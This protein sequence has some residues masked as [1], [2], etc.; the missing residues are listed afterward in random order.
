MVRKSTVWFP[1]EKASADR[2]KKINPVNC[3]KDNCT[4]QSVGRELEK[5]IRAYPGIQ[6]MST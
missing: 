6:S 1:D 4:G 2:E 5:E 3:V